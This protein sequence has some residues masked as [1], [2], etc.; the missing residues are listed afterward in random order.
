M[1]LDRL[2]FAIVY[3][4]C[5]ECKIEKQSEFGYWSVWRI[6]MKIREWLAIAA[7]LT[8]SGFS[9][10]VGAQDLYSLVDAGKQLSQEA[11]AALEELLAKEPEHQTLRVQLIGYY[12]KFEP[13]TEAGQRRIEHIL[14]LTRN[15][16]EARV[17]ASPE[18]QIY[19]YLEADAYSQATSVWSRHLEH[20]PES[21]DIL[22]NSAE[23]YKQSDPKLAIE[24]LERAQEIDGS[25]PEWASELGHI[26]SS[27]MTGS[28]GEPDQDAAARALSQYERAY[29]LIAEAHGDHLLAYL[30]KTAFVAG[31]TEK[32][33]SYANDMLSNDS[34]GWNLGNRV[35]H[36]NLTLGRLALAEGNLEEAN[37]RILKAGRTPGSPQ[38]NSFGPNMALAKDL[39][40]H[41]ETEVVLQYFELC[42]RFWNSD[43]ALE[44]LAEWTAAV[45]AGE[46][47][48]FGANLLY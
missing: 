43:H 14:W 12:N 5:V 10:T 4:S 9:P 6:E 45:N 41:G 47:P 23:F 21:L 20:M 15:Q 37:D 18:G 7:L 22:R 16:P 2:G 48:K 40:E 34:G 1:I 25:N 29:E 38:L 19:Q 33:R 13:G 39:L 46:I 44:R 26:H 28:P 30:A 27:A 35:H 11:V 24:L 32:A 17:L 42:S 8:A 31:E 36:G 3:L